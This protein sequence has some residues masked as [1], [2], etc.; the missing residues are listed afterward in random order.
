MN[1]IDKEAICLFEAKSLGVV[2]GLLIDKKTLK[3]KYLILDGTEPLNYVKYDKILA[4]ADC[5]TL[6]NDLCLT[7]VPDSVKKR[8]HAVFP[9]FGITTDGKRIGRLEDIEFDGDCLK[10]LIF[11]TPIAAEK[12]LRASGNF[13]VVQGEKEFKIAKSV[14]K[15]INVNDLR[16]VFIND[17]S[18]KS[19]DDAPA[20]S[21]TKQSIERSASPSAASPSA[22]SP[23]A[24][25]P[26]AASPS[27]AS[28]S[29][30]SPSAASPSF[31]DNGIENNPLRII[32][33]YHFLLGRIVKTNI[34]SFNGEL[35][36]SENSTITPDVVEK[37]RRYGKLI[38][39]TTSSAS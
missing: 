10:S 3:L 7:T 29:A 36:I 25:S 18:Y 22:A 5:I 20:L 21:D 15:K 11:N 37:A 13:I 2:T 31:S 30:A 17:A 27:A 26:S 6:K 16:Q 28:P 34:F 33:D 1:L 35:I 38:E 24:A 14:P 4:V 39:L 19:E 12:I 32:T 9:V 23:S 8:C